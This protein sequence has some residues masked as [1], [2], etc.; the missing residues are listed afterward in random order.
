MIHGVRFK[1]AERFPEGWQLFPDQGAGAGPDNTRQIY[2][3]NISQNEYFYDPNDPNN[4]LGA[5]P[6]DFM[7]FDGLE[8]REVCCDPIAGPTST[9]VVDIEDECP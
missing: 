5:F 1:V 9:V 6:R 2:L 3:F 8:G 7:T 4:V